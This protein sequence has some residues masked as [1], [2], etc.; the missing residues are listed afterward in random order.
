MKKDKRFGFGQNWKNFL[1]TLDDT[2]ILEAELSLQKMLGVTTLE[3]KSFLD[4][5][6]GSGLFSLAAHRLGATVFSFDYDQNSVACTQELKNRYAKDDPRWS[7]QQGSVLDTGYMKKV[8]SSDIVYSWGVLHHTGDMYSALNHAQEK[9]LP[10][11]T[12]FIA[13]YNDQGAMSRLWKKVKKLYIAMPAFLR[14][15]YVLSIILLEE[16][17]LFIRKIF[18]G[19]NPLPFKR[20]EDKKKD[21]GMS[22]WFDWVDWVGGYPFEVA[23]PEQIIDPL[24]EQ[25]FV[26][27]KMITKAG[28]HG[29]NEY[30]FTKTT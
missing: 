24:M 21:R 3:G 11:G 9:V 4:I 6:S 12:L 8:P 10:Q 15:V 14:P 13:I 20:W 27:K 7:V 19:K 17:Q 26:L 30:V 16:T 18:A 29:C 2:R 25:G 5:G 28:G 1:S 23:R 22:M